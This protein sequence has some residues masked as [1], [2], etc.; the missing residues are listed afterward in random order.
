M[1]ETKIIS[2]SEKIEDNGAPV[3]TE[4]RKFI[5]RGG[6]VLYW[7]IFAGVDKAGNIWLKL[8]NI[9]EAVSMESCGKLDKDK[10]D[11]LVRKLPDSMSG[12][13]HWRLPQVQNGQFYKY[14]TAITPNGLY[15]V[16]RALLR[17]DQ[18]GLAKKAIR[19][20]WN[21]LVHNV[22]PEM[23]GLAARNQAEVLPHEDLPDEVPEAAARPPYMVKQHSFI[24]A[25]KY[26]IR[27]GIDAD[28]EIWL[29]RVD[30]L[31]ALTADI[32]SEEIG[33]LWTPILAKLKS[34]QHKEIMLRKDDQIKYYR[35]G[36]L[37]IS[38]LYAVTNALKDNQAEPV[39]AAADKFWHW[40][41]AEVIFPMLKL[42][43][44][45]R[46]AEEQD[47]SEELEEHEPDPKVQKC[48]EVLRK[49]EQAQKQKQAPRNPRR[50]SITLLEFTELLKFNGIDIPLDKLLHYFRQCEWIDKDPR[51]LPT[52]FALNSD[53]FTITTKRFPDG[54]MTR[55]TELTVK[56]QWYFLRM[57]AMLKSEAIDCICNELLPERHIDINDA[58]RRL[59]RQGR[60]AADRRWDAGID[61]IARLMHCLLSD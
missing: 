39:K 45:Q 15:E 59:K 30:V 21:W 54:S 9:R 4:W 19:K 47:E 16:T 28:D 8:K 3:V 27:V 46:W 11:E 42:K 35:V 41:M 36:A 55:R 61:I 56:G 20:I 17:S 13:V 7:P 49:I 14:I 25:D 43:N 53:L 34:K 22:F 24:Y 51:I 31:N 52:S 2:S 1:D 40:V 10:F 18:P 33:T 48:E 57:F 60:K 58:D 32:P 50:E 44:K 5:Y 29:A 6:C 23:R 12:E 37:N 38:G 26:E